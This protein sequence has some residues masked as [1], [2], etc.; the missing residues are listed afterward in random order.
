MELLKNERK[1]VLELIIKRQQDLYVESCMLY[2][3]LLKTKNNNTELKNT[4]LK[5][6]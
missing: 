1:F 3:K 4:G 6:D 5:H 2:I